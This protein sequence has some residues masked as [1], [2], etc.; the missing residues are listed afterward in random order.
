MSG[1]IRFVQSGSLD[2]TEKFLKGVQKLDVAKIVQRQAEL[3]VE[4]L[5]AATPKDT[6]RTAESWR[7]TVSQNGGG[8]SITWHN[9][10]IENGFPVAVMLQYG[11]GTGTGGYVHGRDFINPAIRPIFD[12]IAEEVWKAVTSA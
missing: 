3:G 11:H 4:A 10:D 5:A 1:V 7:A 12:K 9:T 6:G 8:V 2:K